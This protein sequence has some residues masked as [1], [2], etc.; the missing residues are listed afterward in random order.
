MIS[1]IEL[2]MV[3]WVQWSVISLMTVN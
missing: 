1:H 2:E 3:F